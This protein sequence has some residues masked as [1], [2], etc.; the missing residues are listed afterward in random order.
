MSKHKRLSERLDKILQDPIEPDTYV[1]PAKRMD[2]MIKEHTSS[3][4]PAR[5]PQR[6]A[7]QPAATR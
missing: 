2:E 4:G 1:P 6:P 3:Q 7:K 5:L